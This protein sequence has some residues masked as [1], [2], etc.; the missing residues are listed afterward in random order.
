MKEQKKGSPLGTLWSWGKAHHGKFV[1][2]IIL[3]ILGVACQMIPYFCVVNVISKI[4]AGETAFSAYLPVCL[5]ALAGYCGKVLFSNL[6][7]VISHNAAY[8]TLRDLRERVVEKLAKVP[9]GTILDTPSGHYKSIIVDR[10]EGMEVPFAHLLPEMTSNML[11]PLFIIV[12]LFVLD[13][14]MALLSLATLF[15]GLVIMSIGMR[16]YATEGAGA[17]AASKKM[18]DAVVE[19]IGG[20]EVVKAFSQ[21]A[22][23]Y[24]KYADAVRG[25][26]DYYIKW[27]ANSQK[28]M[29]S[30]NA[31]IPSVLLCVLP[32]G[33]ALWL[34]GSLENHDLY[35][36]GYL[37]PWTC[38]ANHGGFFFHWLFG[39]AGKKYRGNRQ[40]L[41]CRRT[42]PCQ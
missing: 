37:L 32:G 17:M 23:S 36:G 5:V 39:Y 1:F 14:R 40:Y 33:M 21:S 6:S 16:N 26:A 19:Y 28:T 3:A 31:V 22:G 20:I 42:S 15:I 35:G 41:K 34:S 9:M 2:S 7:T 8:S 11:V 13:W 38:W 24:E 30:Y 29:C 10:I 25:N 12:Y 18:A 4:F 27:M